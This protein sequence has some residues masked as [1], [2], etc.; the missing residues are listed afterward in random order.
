MRLKASINQLTDIDIRGIYKYVYNGQLVQKVLHADPR[1]NWRETN[2]NHFLKPRQIRPSQFLERMLRTT[3]DVGVRSFSPMIEGLIYMAL[4]VI[5]ITGLAKRLMNHIFFALSLRRR[6][7]NTLG[8][9]SKLLTAVLV[10]I[11][12]E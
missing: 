10:V 3:T 7:F 11:K 9:F 2:P 12:V 5:L 4:L 8:A 1:L 6:I